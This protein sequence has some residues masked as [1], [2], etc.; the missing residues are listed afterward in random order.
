MARPYCCNSSEFTDKS[1]LN[2]WLRLVSCSADQSIRIWDYQSPNKVTIAA[3]LENAHD[4]AIYSVSW[5]KNGPW[6]LSSGGD[7]RI[8]LWKWTSAELVLLAELYRPHGTS[9]INCVQ[10]NP[11]A[12]YQ[13][14]FASCGD[15]GVVKIWDVPPRLFEI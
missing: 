15:D 7:A 12:E 14:L 4:R 10:W 11:T 1:P 6:I 9:D 3:T 13:N 2:F 5:H 8:K